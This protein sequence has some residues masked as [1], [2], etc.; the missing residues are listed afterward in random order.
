[1]IRVGIPPFL[2]CSSKG[3]KRFS[4]FS[5]RIRRRGNKS[6][7]ELYQA[8]KVFD[9]GV[10]GLTWQ[11]AKGKKPINIEECKV[12]YT[13]LWTEYIQENPEL[14]KILKIYNGLSDIFGQPGHQCQATVL[15][16]IRNTFSGVS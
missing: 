13:Q 1:M 12:F 5:A 10:T 7:E 4:A 11:E 9:G 15:W 14:L 8:Y 6:I 2:E 3:D 16:N